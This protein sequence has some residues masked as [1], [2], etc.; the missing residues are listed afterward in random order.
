MLVNCMAFFPDVQSFLQLPHKLG[1]VSK[2]N[3]LFL[4]T[5]Y[6]SESSDLGIV[7]NL[8]LDMDRLAF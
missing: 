4:P 7:F 6:Y 5:Q 2:N 3:L 8:V 1:V